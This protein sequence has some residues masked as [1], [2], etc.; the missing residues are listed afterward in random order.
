MAVNNPKGRINYEPNS[1][2]MEGGPRESPA[3]G[4]TS[5]PAEESGSKQRV[6]SE[7]FADHYSQARQFFISQ[8]PIE[9]NHIIHALVFELS[10]VQTL[11][12][13]ERMVGHLLNIDKG[14]AQE[15]AKGLRLQTMPKPLSAARPTR[16][17][18]KASPALSI[19]QNGPDSFAG[20]KVGALVTDGVDATILSTLK[21]ALTG[22]GALLKLIAPEIGGVTDSEGVLHPADEKLE[23]GP[24]VLFDAVALLPSQE[25]AALLAK[26][27]AARDFIADANAHRKFIGFVNFAMPLL[28]NVIGK[29]YLDGGFA[30]LKTGKDCSAFVKQCRAL[31]FWERDDAQR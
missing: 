3:R 19:I 27:P 29:D 1:F 14:L 16:Q 26:L 31:R 21:K 5:F 24:S 2:G 25:G 4:F 11:A 6:R 13:R 15:V 23:G 20:R 17:D 18:L 7:T 10:K 8:T 22:E 9:Q 28:R 30:E 12:I